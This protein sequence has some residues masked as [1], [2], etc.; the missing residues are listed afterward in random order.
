MK[1]RKIINYEIG[2]TGNRTGWTPEMITNLM[3][4]LKKTWNIVMKHLNIGT[5]KQD[6]VQAGHFKC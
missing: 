6:P 4:N 2:K 3:G 5:L 1:E